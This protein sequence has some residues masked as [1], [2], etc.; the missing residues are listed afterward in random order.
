LP[1]QAGLLSSHRRHRTVA[2]PQFFKW[3]E[4]HRRARRDLAPA[5]VRPC[6]AAPKEGA[7]GAA[8]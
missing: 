2:R 3:L 5:R 6:R 1:I 4:D 8:P 7:A